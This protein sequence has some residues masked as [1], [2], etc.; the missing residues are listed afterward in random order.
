VQY[1]SPDIFE[2]RLGP[3]SSRR[4]TIGRLCNYSGYNQLWKINRIEARLRSSFAAQFASRSRPLMFMEV[5][6]LLLMVGLITWVAVVALMERKVRVAPVK[7]KRP[8][9]AAQIQADDSSSAPDDAFGSEG[10]GELDIQ[11]DDFK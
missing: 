6:W 4:L 10:A 11:F 7:A 5:L 3:L 1:F 8:S 2:A 9:P